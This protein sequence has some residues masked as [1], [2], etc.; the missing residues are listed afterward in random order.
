MF[1]FV[2]VRKF[3]VLFMFSIYAISTTEL[4]Q[5]LKMPVFVSHFIEHKNNDTKMDL[6]GF[7]VHHYGGHEKDADW[8][9]DMRLPFMKPSDVL[10]VVSIPIPFEDY[11]ILKNQI[12][13]FAKYTDAYQ[14]PHIA[15]SM[16][17]SIWQ[18]PK[19]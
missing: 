10:S 7:V 4:I 19:I 17:S 11:A 2:L 1:N 8:E 12:K 18:P 9:T 3:L 5:L 16:L 6:I 13:V 15:K 14:E